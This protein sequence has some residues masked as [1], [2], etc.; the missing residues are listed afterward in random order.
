MPDSDRNGELS[1]VYTHHPSAWAA[2]KIILET[3][4]ELM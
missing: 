4:S 3:I 1:T 2:L